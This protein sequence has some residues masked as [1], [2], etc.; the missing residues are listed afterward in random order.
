VLANAGSFETP[1]VPTTD[2]GF[3]IGANPQLEASDR[4]DLTHAYVSS[5][6]EEVLSQERHKFAGT[7]FDG[8]VD[9]APTTLSKS[10]PAGFS[11]PRKAGA[12]TRN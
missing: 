7:G 1:V 12:S 11:R 8:V 5:E 6:I 2:T 9:Q 4:D 10:E 3:C